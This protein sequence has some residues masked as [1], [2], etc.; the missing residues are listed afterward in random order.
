MN[1]AA[2]AEGDGTMKDE[3][4]DDLNGRKVAVVG[5]TGGL[6]RAIGRLLAARGASV[7]VV[8]RTFRDADVPGMAFVQADRE[9]MRD[10]EQAA[11]ALNAEKLDLLVLTTG[12]FAA[13]SARTPPRASSGTSPFRT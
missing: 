1:A 10:A 6:G 11:D 13:P 5:G 2:T 12:I 8:G 3:A 9:T 4:S 7:M